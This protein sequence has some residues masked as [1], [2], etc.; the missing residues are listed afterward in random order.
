MATICG[1]DDDGG[2]GGLQSAMKVGEA[3]QVEHMDLVY[4]QHARHKLSNTLVDVLV[5]DFVDFHSK[6][7]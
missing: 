7:V 4:K 5:H 3:L 6:F 2:Y 1:K